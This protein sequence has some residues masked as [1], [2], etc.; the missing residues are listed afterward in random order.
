MT[1]DARL[2]YR[3]RG[4]ADGDW[5][6]YAHSVEE[7]ILHCDIE[8]VSIIFKFKFHLVF[9]KWQIFQMK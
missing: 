7:R 2:G 6:Y 5:K 8:N 9:L 4:D 1:L 3:N